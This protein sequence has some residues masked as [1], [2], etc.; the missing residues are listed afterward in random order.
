MIKKESNT[1][2]PFSIK[3][4]KKLSK[5]SSRQSITEQSSRQGN[6]SP[7]NQ[8]KKT[9]SRMSSKIGKRS[10]SPGKKVKETKFEAGIEEEV[11]LEDVDF[12]EDQNITLIDFLNIAKD[13]FSDK[14][15][16]SLTCYLPFSHLTKISQLTNCVNLEDS[17]LS[18]N[19]RKKLAQGYVSMQEYEKA[20]RVNEK[21]QE[22]V[23]PLRTEFKE[24]SK[25]N[26]KVSVSLNS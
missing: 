10:K 15:G 22:E 16:M 7:S 11:G 3:N 6:T 4:R 23:K 2:S 24:I 9:Y 14:E 20:R 19:A 5:L 12:D 13:H 17:V 21:L 25:P 8:S 26:S 1:A 18:S